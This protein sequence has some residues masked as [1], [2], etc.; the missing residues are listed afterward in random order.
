MGKL[1]CPR[2]GKGTMYEKQVLNALSRRDNETYICT[3]CGTAEAFVDMGMIGEV[4]WA[5]PTARAEEKIKALVS[6]GRIRLQNA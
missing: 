1:I 4:E 3:E 2:C 5:E 6:A